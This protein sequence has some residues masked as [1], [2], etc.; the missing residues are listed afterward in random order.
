MGVS[1]ATGK[2]GNKRVIDLSDWGRPLARMVAKRLKNKPIS[3]IQVT[4]LHLLLTIYCSWLILNGSTVVAC[5]LLVIKG[6]IDAVDGELARI[7]NKPSHVGRYWDTI[8]DSIGLILIMCSFG[9]LLEWDALITSLIILATLFQYSLFNH[10]SIAMRTLSSGDTTSRIDESTKPVAYPW[11]KQ[12]TVDLFHSVYLLFFSWQDRIISIFSGKGSKS[13][14]FEFTI[15]SLLGF[16]FQSLAFLMLALTKQ[17]DYVPHLI[18][19][20][21]VAI[22]VIVLVRSRIVPN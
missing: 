11:E 18:L 19:V 8:A 6:V 9:I 1:V 21:N 5:A 15:S 10:Y 13:L 2:Y 12:R 3:V 22:M 20:V 4:N 14:S 17:L 7:R 16:G